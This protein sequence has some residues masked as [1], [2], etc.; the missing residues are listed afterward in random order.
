M[1][2]ESRADSFSSTVTPWLWLWSSFKLIKWNWTIFP[3]HRA[4]FRSALV[5][6]NTVVE[7]HCNTFIYV[8]HC[9]CNLLNVLILMGDSCSRDRESDWCCLLCRPLL[10]SCAMVWWTRCV[11]ASLLA[12]ATAVAPPAVQR[13]GWSCWTLWRLSSAWRWA[14]T[15]VMK[16]W[17]TQSV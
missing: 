2:G 12:G 9:Q 7:K 6:S 1:L 4:P 8:L 3:A 13:S 14:T 17:Q 10:P 5:W 15:A 16:R 11:A